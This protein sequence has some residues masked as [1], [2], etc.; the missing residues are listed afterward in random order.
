MGIL[1]MEGAV[2]ALELED[3]TVRIRRLPIRHDKQFS[4]GMPSLKTF[5]TQKRA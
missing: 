3:A 4:K 5:S 2:V 1:L